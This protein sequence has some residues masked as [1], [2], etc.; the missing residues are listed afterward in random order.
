MATH[1]QFT[2]VLMCVCGVIQLVTKKNSLMKLAED[3]DVFTLTFSDLQVISSV[4]VCG[5]N[6][7]M[8]HVQIVRD[9]NEWLHQE[10]FTIWLFC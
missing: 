6:F 9:D 4:P 5:V 8:F 3:E 7:V 1:V 10:V 2:V